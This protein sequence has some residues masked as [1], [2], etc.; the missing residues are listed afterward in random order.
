M[1]LLLPS[2]R[3]CRLAEDLARLSALSR[4]QALPLSELAGRGTER[5]FALALL[6]VTL[7]F[8]LPFPTLGMSTPV[9]LA[10]AMASASLLLGRTPVLPAR[11]GTLE[12]RPWLLG[13][14]LATLSRAIAVAGP[15][16][17][18]RLGLLLRPAPMRCALG[19]SLLVSAV[20]LALPVPLPLSNFFPAAAILLLAAGIIES[21]GLLV[22][23]GHCACAAVC[24]VVYGSWQLVTALGERAIRIVA[25]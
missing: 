11:L 10:V 20:V 4:E 17:R 9:G 2:P 15:F 16:V 3:V 12:V 13:R 18:P 25:G 14:L 5:G 6:L 23:A 22:L 24:A 21:D 7:P 1:P 19:V 8:V